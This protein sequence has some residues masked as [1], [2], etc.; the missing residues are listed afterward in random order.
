[1]DTATDTKQPEPVQALT[2]AASSMWYVC[3]LSK[4]GTPDWGEADGPHDNAKDAAETVALLNRLACIKK[5]ERFICEVRIFNAVESTEG[6]NHAA[7]DTLNS[8]QSNV[9][10]CH[11][12]ARR[13]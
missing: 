4:H 9:E 10:H 1:M 3:E 5:K 8:I 11:K 13:S 6:L 7:I 12:E 2:T